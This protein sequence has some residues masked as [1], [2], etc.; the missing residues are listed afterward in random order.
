MILEEARQSP[1][2]RKSVFVPKTSGW[3]RELV[4][5]VRDALVDSHKL[6]PP[7]TFQSC[8]I[9]YSHADEEFVNALYSRLKNE[10]I[11]LW[12]VAEHMQ[13]GRKIHEEIDNAVRLYDRLLLVLSEASMR[14]EWVATEIRTAIDQET[15]SENRK[16]I[17]I[18]L[19]GFDEIRTWHSFNADVGKDMAVELREYYIPDFCEWRDKLIF[20]REIARLLD[21][22]RI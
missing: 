9:S 8:F 20:E 22:L 16:L 7:S 2:L 3:A 21:A 14:S 5:I 10:G 1:R 18:R 4:E 11:Q 6:L 13:P 19:V 17:P 15:K 12:Y